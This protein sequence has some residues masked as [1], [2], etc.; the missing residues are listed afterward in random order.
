MNDEFWH[1]RWAKNEIGFHLK[2]TNPFL[3]KYW[4]ALQATP[5]DSIFVPLCGKSNDLI[6]LS[7][8]VK[9]VIGIE[10]SQQAVEDFFSDNSLVPTIHKTEHFIEYRYKNIT[11]LCGDFFK[12]TPAQLPGCHFIYDRASLIAFPPDMRKAYAKK[13]HE[14][15]PDEVRRLLITIEYPQHEMNGPPFSVPTTEVQ[16]HFEQLFGIEKLESEDILEKAKRFK[17]KGVTQMFEYVYLLSK[18]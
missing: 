3:I 5:N 6:W 2:D 1:E 16:Q 7:E 9:Q 10:L 14:L 12:L 4:N 17:D 13:L 18:I 11:L 15:M 8:R